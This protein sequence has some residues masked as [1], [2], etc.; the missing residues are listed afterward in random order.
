MSVFR[1]VAAVAVCSA[2]LPQLALALTPA[3][4]KIGTGFNDTNVTVPYSWLEDAQQ[5][6]D[7]CEA[8]GSCETFTFYNDTNPGAC[9]LQGSSVTSITSKDAI[10]GP[11]NCSVAP[12]GTEEEAAVATTAASGASFPWW[13]F[14]LVG[15][16][17]AGAGG[18]TA[19]YFSSASGSKKKSSRAVKVPKD[20]EAPEETDAMPLMQGTELPQMPLTTGYYTAAPIYTYSQAPAP[21]Y[22]HTAPA[23]YSYAQAAP[24]A[25]YALAPAAVSTFDRL[26]ANGDGVLSAEEFARMGQA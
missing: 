23:V 21:A 9:W 2:T 20:Q 19:F 13:G 3:C 22:A 7:T 17:V 18:A 4:A 8:M 11:K 1:S 10:S 5:C 12:A 6:Q 16:G 26:D 14:L 25:T 24:Q 15:L